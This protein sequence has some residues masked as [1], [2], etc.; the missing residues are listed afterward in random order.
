M[1]LGILATLYPTHPFSFKL[2]N[3]AGLISGTNNV[4]T[5]ASA[6]E[7]GECIAVAKPSLMIDAVLQEGNW[8]GWLLLSKCPVDPH[9]TKW[10][11]IIEQVNYT[12]Q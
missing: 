10:Q 8:G 12:M 4:E 6:I 3:L 9:D 1:P 5:R 7:L 2:Q 11:Q